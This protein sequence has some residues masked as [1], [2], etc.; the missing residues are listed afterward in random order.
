[1]NK[2]NDS[3]IPK[4]PFFGIG[5]VL[6]YLKKY[7]KVMAVMILGGAVG[8]V[9]DVVIPVFQRYALDSRRWPTTPPPSWARGSR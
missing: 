3:R 7:K 8:S 5:K 9:Y 6:P 1:M 4:L 2:K